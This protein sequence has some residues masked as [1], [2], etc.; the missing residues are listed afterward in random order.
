MM[1]IWLIEPTASENQQLENKQKLFTHKE[2]HKDDQR[3]GKLL[4]SIKIPT[5]F[6]FQY[7]QN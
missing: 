6:E 1:K 7:F 2:S 5:L 4:Q 3:G